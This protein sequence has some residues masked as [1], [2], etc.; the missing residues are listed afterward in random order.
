MIK[1]HTLEICHV[2]KHY[3]KKRALFD[4]TYTFK[5]GIYGLLGPNGA[6]KSTLMYLITDNLI[7]DKNSG[8]IKWDNEDIHKLGKKYR[9][10]LG[11]MPQQQN[12]YPT[13]TARQFMGYIAAL[14]NI[15][16]NSA[17]SEIET[18]LDTVEL[19]EAA[20]KKIGGFSG[21]MKQRLLFA[22]CLLGNPSLVV[23]DEPT[24]GLD[25]RQRVILREKIEDYG[26]DK[27]II[28]AT[29]ITSD[30][31]TIADCIIMMQDGKI[32][33]N[34]SVKEL[35][36]KVHCDSKTLEALYMQYYDEEAKKNVPG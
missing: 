13:M 33:D 14:K 1:E 28:I 24:A 5:P 20:D 32:I 2:T 3:G 25:P 7:P 26:R 15:N 6:G 29:H 18:L 11:F 19:R 4:F 12:L 30:I 16:R 8:I 9:S 36:N 10:N 21:G 17:V 31:E 23:L 27:I 34:G 22:S 35:V